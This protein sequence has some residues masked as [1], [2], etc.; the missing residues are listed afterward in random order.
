MQ[1]R[2]Q[3]RSGRQSTVRQALVVIGTM[4][5]LNGGP[6]LADDFAINPLS[7]NREVVGNVG[8]ACGSDMRSDGAPG[9]DSWNGSVIAQVNCPDGTSGRGQATQNSIVAPLELSVSS[10]A[11]GT[12][13]DPGQ[14][15]GSINASAGS[16]FGF[17]FELTRYA[18]VTI[19]ASVIAQGGDTGGGNASVQIPGIVDVS[20]SGCCAGPPEEAN[21]EEMVFLPAGVYTILATAS[22]AT[23]TNCCCDFGAGEY[24]VSFI[25]QPCGDV[26]FDGLVNILDLAVVLTS[27]GAC[28]PP[29]EPCPGDVNGDGVVNVL[30]LLAVIQNWG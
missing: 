12:S 30:D 6:L 27:W 15:C 9:L 25:V 29:E 28:P 19:N 7:Q 3:M 11:V 23:S 21:A 26:N 13:N 24:N 4:S 16:V 18:A 5:T 8:T 1:A 17:E 20:V 22:G 10:E 2:H 14:T